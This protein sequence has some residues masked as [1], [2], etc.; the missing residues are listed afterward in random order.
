MCAAVIRSVNIVLNAQPL[1]RTLCTEGSS[2]NGQRCQLSKLLSATSMRLPID[3]AVLLRI[4]NTK[5]NA[6]PCS[7]LSSDNDFVT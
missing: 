5:S 2:R 4:L 6:T 1:S 3:T 7:T